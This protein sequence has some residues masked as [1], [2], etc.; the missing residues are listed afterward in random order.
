MSF[1]PA[2][3]IG[4]QA[5]APVIGGVM[6]AKGLRREAR[7]MEEG[8]RRDESQGAADSVAAY[9]ES[10]MAIGED[11]AALAGSGFAIGSGSAQ[12]VLSQALIEREMEGMNIRHQAYLQAQEKRAAATDR[13]KA[14]KTAIY[15]GILNG[16]TAAIGGAAQ[17]RSDAR[18]E[19]RNAS[20]RTSQR[21]GYGLGG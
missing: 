18:A 1:L 11:M 8:A 14:A 13:R 17:M 15:M 4:L 20:T 3:A 6:E 12:D 16:A 10:R 5:A 7:A 19:R 9:R 21:A 2:L